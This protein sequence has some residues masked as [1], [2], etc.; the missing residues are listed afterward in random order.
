MPVGLM[1]AR[2]LKHVIACGPAHGGGIH[3]A[4]PSMNADSSCNGSSALSGT[5]G[6]VRLGGRDTGPAPEPDASSTKVDPRNRP[7]PATRT[8]SGVGSIDH[9]TVSV[10][11]GAEALGT[12]AVFHARSALRARSSARR[13]V[14]L[15]AA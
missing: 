15:S 10:T 7:T 2:S 12:A 1:T 11:R 14:A 3:G 9:S 4:V 8:E 6:L 13:E 5:R